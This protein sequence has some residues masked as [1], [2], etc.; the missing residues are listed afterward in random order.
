VLLGLLYGAGSGDA[1][2]PLSTSLTSL[3]SILSLLDSKRGKPICDNQ[4]TIE[5]LLPSILEKGLVRGKRH[6]MHLS[7]DVE[8]ARKV[9][10]RRGNPVILQ[11]DAGRMHWDGHKFLLSANGV[12]LTDS[13]AP[14]YLTRR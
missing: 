2:G 3:R 10:V 5:R 9:G 13:V 8:T 4:G 12:W 7:K 6:H 14:A 1:G 11:V